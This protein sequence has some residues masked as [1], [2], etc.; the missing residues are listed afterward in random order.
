M[1]RD[2]REG[3]EM[4]ISCPAW[5]G[6]VAG[7]R[8][9]RPALPQHFCGIHR[10]PSTGAPVSR[11][12]RLLELPLPCP[13][14]PRDKAGTTSWFMPGEEVPPMERCPRR[15]NRRCKVCATSIKSCT[16]LSPLKQYSYYVEMVW[17][18]WQCQDCCS[19]H[20]QRFLGEERGPGGRLR[21][22]SCHWGISVLTGLWPLASAF[23]YTCSQ[24]NPSISSQNCLWQWDKS[25]L[26]LR[27]GGT[28]GVRTQ[29]TGAGWS[30]VM[31]FPGTCSECCPACS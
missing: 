12:V 29:L 22:G 3:W 6:R 23:S 16:L 21:S 25:T 14:R 19:Q 4:P 5:W 8:S 10:W 30:E 2:G 26:F 18:P 27:R 24:H 13:V 31:S 28:Y 17:P 1:Q 11:R 20:K 15:E 7:R 9:P